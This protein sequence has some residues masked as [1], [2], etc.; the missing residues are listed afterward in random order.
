MTRRR[1][2]ARGMAWYLLGNVLPLAA[3][4]AAIP[5][6]IGRMGPSR[7]GLLT[8]VWM[9]VGYS[10]FLDLGIGRA[11]THAVAERLGRNDVAEIPTVIRGGVAM[12]FVVGVVGFLL[13]A[14]TSRWVAM[15]FLK[16]PPELVPEA[17]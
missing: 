8:F 15:R 3:A 7:F 17:A 2:L 12:L 6:L 14:T 16:V 1:R 5:A 9:I 13:L 4:V 10:A 11:L